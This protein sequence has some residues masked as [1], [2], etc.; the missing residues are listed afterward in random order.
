MVFSRW[1]GAAILAA[2]LLLAPAT[3]SAVTIDQ[4]VSLSKAGVSEAVI[5]ALLD[6]DGSILAIEPDQIVALKREGL[7]DS[8]IMAMLRNGRPEGDE[9]ARAVS[10]ANAAAILSSLALSAAPTPNLVIV[11]HG[12]ER[13]DT[14][15]SFYSGRRRFDLPYDYAYS[16]TH[17][18]GY[19]DYRG[20][21]YGRDRALC[22]AQVNT[23]GGRG[24]SYVTECPAVMQRSSRRNTR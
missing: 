24:P 14:Y 8:L 10:D 11:G 18:G 12:P 13:P 22:L 2:G 20:D 7:S 9:A 3:A 16:V 4:I 17:K 5:L 23:T 1:M 6:R 21:S 15:S 19:K